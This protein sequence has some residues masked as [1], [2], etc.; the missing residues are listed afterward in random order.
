MLRS[1][2]LFWL[3]CDSRRF[4]CNF[5]PR[6]FRML[7]PALLGLA[8]FCG[9]EAVAQSPA[10]TT[11]SIAV[12]SSG[13][14]VTSV[15]AGTVVTLTAAVQS[16]ANSVTKGQVNFC[17]ASASYCTDIHLLG[18][19]QLTSA[20]TATLKLRPGIGSHS[21]K[22][23]F[24]GTNIY[25]GSVSGA[26]ALTATGT[27]P[28]LATAATINQT[29][30]WGAYTLSATVTETGNIAPPTGLVSFLDTNYGNAVLGTGILGSATRGVNWTTVDSSAP[31]VAAVFF[32]VAD[33][34][35]DGIPDLFVKDYFGTYDVLLGKG[36]GTFTVLGSPFGPTSETGSFIVG[37]FN[38]DG[39]PDVA[40]IN[41][42]E[43]ASSG[44]ITIFLGNGDGTF[45][46]L[47]SSPAIG[48]NPSGIAA[49]DINGDGNVDLAV[50]Q[51]D[52]SGNGQIVVFFGNGDGTFTQ[53]SSTTSVTSTASS[54]IP[55]DVN[56]DGKIDLVLSGI[57]QSG[58]TILLGNGDG[59]FTELAGPSQAGE[60]TA[61]VADV[62]NDGI[63][64]LVFPAANTSYL[65]VFLGNGDGTFTEAP[66]SPNVNL[67]IGSAVIGDLN[68]DG[69][70][71]VVY[72]NGDGAGVLFGKGDG[73]F[74]QAPA[75]IA[76][77][78]D[79][80][81]NLVVADF[82]GDGWPDVLTIDGNTRTVEDALTQP[83]ET[84]TAS[85]NVSIP[86]AGAH[87]ADASYPGDSNYNSS[88][89][90][91]VSLWGAPPV[92]T[93]A[94]T[95][96]SGGSAVS[97]VTTGTA[98]TLTA[99]VTA[100]ANPVTAGQVDFCDA[101]ATS[102]SD[103]HLLGTV[104]LS[105][106]G[107][108]AFNFVPGPGS[109]SYKAVFVEDGY[110][111]TSSSAAASLTVGPAPA[112]SYSDTIAI[113][114]GGT[115]GDYSLT[116]TVVGYGGSAPPTG[117]VSFLDTSFGNAQLAAATLGSST[118]GVG[119]LISQTQAAG[120]DLV[121][122]AVGDFNQDGIPDVAVLWTNSSTGGLSVTI[123]T[124]KGDGTFTAG[125]SISTGIS[126]AT[127]PYM[128]TGDFNGDGKTDLA[129]LT[130]GSTSFTNSVTI[131][132]SNGDGTFAAPQTSAAFNQPNSGGDV[133][134]GSMTAADFNGDGKLDLAIVGDCVASCGVTILLGNG[135]GT[136]GA[137]TTLASTQ[138]FG[139]IATGDFNGD[140]IP[141]LI[142]TNYFEDNSSP[143][144]FLGKGDGTFTAAAASFTLDYFPTSI[145]VGDFNGDGVLDLAFSDLSGVEIAL[146]NGDGT[147]NETA[148]SPISVPSELYSVIA[149]D[150]NQDG[151]VD[152]A[153][154]DNYNDRIVLLIGAGDGTFTVT[155]TTPV[156]S[157][158]FLGPFAI[159]AADFNEDG[160]PD[161]AML[162]K[163]TVTASILINEP[164]ETATASVTGIAP[165][166][167]GTHNVEASY[168]G[169]SN[170][171]SGVSGT[172][173][174]TA[175]LAPLVISPTSGT[176][177]S[178]QTLTISE[179]I[180]GA[181]IYYEAI[182]PVS[183]NG[184][185]QYTGP[186]TLNAQGTE[187]I[188]AYA[189]ETGYQSSN[190]ASA[191]YS[192]N[193]AIA[194]TPVITPAGGSYTS[195]QS[196][197][198]TDATTGATIY[199]TTDGTNPTTSSTVY[200]GPITVASSETINAVAVATGFTESA[201]ASAVYTINAPTPTLG[202]LSP[203]FVAA[204]GAAFSLTINGSGFMPNSTAYWG[205]T[206]LTTQY[207]G[208]SQLKAQITAAQI[209]NAGV[210]AVTV[211]TPAPGGGTSNTMQFEVDT[212]GSTTPPSFTTVTASVSPGS[213]ASYPVTL[214]SSASN[215]TVNCLNL[216]TGAT[217]SYS[218]NSSTLTIA[219]SPTTPAGTYQITVVFTETLPG[220]ASALIFVPF[221][222]LPL[223]VFRKRWTTQQVWLL[224]VLAFA[225]AA[226]AV[227]GCGG[228][229]SGGTTPPQ[230]PTYQVTSS[231]TVTLTVQ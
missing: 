57:G 61:S 124:G 120:G 207:V 60:A 99:T 15:S 113:S 53:A 150:F 191:T 136:F 198:I 145:V 108:A 83:T 144:I 51:T 200:A 206:A 226:V 195:P 181:T 58:I 75:T 91:T 31:S 47:G 229:S 169:D 152:L 11:T 160:A 129:I 68:Q 56:G 115:T 110:G 101:S 132:L 220:S 227:S 199:Y 64:D 37:D 127:G 70:P 175:G 65:T 50:S 148:A 130:M 102:C 19:A 157:Q 209:A 179:S 163:N 111:L 128:I 143:T 13:T 167:A 161:L 171:G 76:Y 212:A 66:S 118:A 158:D 208:A 71:D 221:L 106:N 133:Y 3:A 86:V 46:V 197:T 7:T 225:L 210:N 138:A 125:T 149:G 119:W 14:A 16:G 170:Y 2:S 88:T 182:G 116:A 40:A 156:V 123:F 159:A 188:E 94:L 4:S 155:P 21:Y 5:I 103:I 216:P 67:Q 72:T 8:A 193:I 12:T 213:T 222:L 112:V 27:I 93:T 43:Y 186:I 231:G 202:N 162:T 134:F 92:T 135:D 42:A 39:I 192:L 215:V 18:T 48:M 203:A 22:A 26:S 35:G 141:D 36:D 55:A 98:V 151:K 82:N 85:A 28:S 33:L 79:F 9:A 174:L 24:P 44:T 49:A 180:P 77:P 107:T 97:S 114:N 80:S 96:T 184:F 109:H 121:A 187:M 147:F 131:L 211:Q 139:Q 87:L 73:S 205:T 74:I 214:P 196:V 25:S 194:A 1:R 178:A 84:A 137:G 183:T 204:G 105:S 100:G 38:N 217:C 90:G 59:T 176:Y 78:Y 81:G 142:A 165:V 177:S 218:A 62:N 89:S 190:Y 223:V 23:V 173:A 95:V 230:N 154:V 69:I 6:T 153:G 189:T 17:D 52:S 34:N 29:G 224:A 32:A 219:T 164:T 117:N 140:G 201:V 168:A 146:G 41:A 166:G 10:A 20:G 228:G 54:I 104:A 30:S 45:T 63:P 185:V 172:V 122:E 126:D